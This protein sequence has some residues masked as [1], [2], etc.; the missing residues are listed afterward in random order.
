MLERWQKERG[1]QVIVATQ[2]THLF[3]I[4][5]PGTKVLLGGPLA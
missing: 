2:S 1:G 4:A 5:A 3:S